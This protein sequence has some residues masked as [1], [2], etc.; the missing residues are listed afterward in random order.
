MWNTLLKFLGLRKSRASRILGRLSMPFS[1]GYLSPNWLDNRYEQVKA[2]REWVFVAVRCLMNS[3]A[4]LTP[5]C[6]VVRSAQRDQQKGR[7]R[8]KGLNQV[9]RRK[10]LTQLSASEDLDPLP[11]THPLCQLLRHPSEADSFADFVAELI[12]FLQ[13]TGNAYIW[14]PNAQAFD[15]PAEI[16]VL[17]SHWVYPRASTAS[18]LL[19][20]YEI[21]PV[22]SSVRI[23]DIPVEEVI[24]VKYKSALSK[25]DGFAP[26]TAGARWVDNSSAV[27]QSRWHMFANLA[28]LG[29]MLLLDE[30]Q[31]TV[32]P[33][34]VERIENRFMSRFSGPTKAGRP[35]ILSNVKDIKPYSATPVEMAYHESSEQARDY[36]LA[37][38]GVPRQVAGFG[39]Q[40]TFGS[41]L[42][43][44]QWYCSQTVDPLTSMLGN[45]FS[46]HLAPRFP[47]GRRLRVWWDSCAPR[48]PAQ[49]LAEHQ[50]Y[51]AAGAL[52]LNEVRQELG[53]EPYEFGGWDPILP[54]G[55]AP[56][57][58]A[59][60]EDPFQDLEFAL[61]RGAEVSTQAEEEQQG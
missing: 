38:F 27:E 34:D 32:T 13:L 29:P 2:H 33:E 14:A 51:L 8:Y 52:T 16:F 49:V 12:L 53:K 48:D 56:M 6:A 20:H 39:E 25:I 60:G 42:A 40:M 31:V 24:H 35:I 44:I 47:E 17:P 59:T 21:R 55:V 5:E 58:F 19:D 45:A 7:W 18:G 30:Q 3:V 46:K 61:P 23:L 22:Y 26:T 1:G 36:V 37:L 11:L 50:A 28:L 15:Y 43:I 54:V 10:A 4:Q 57:P 41:N 9:E